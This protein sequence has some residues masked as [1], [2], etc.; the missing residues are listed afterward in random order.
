M[1]WGID[2]SLVTTNLTPDFGAP[3][4]HFQIVVQLISVLVYLWISCTTTKKSVSVLQNPGTAIDWVMNWWW[5]SLPCSTKDFSC[6]SACVRSFSICNAKD[7]VTNLTNSN[8]WIE[9]DRDERMNESE[10]WLA[11]K[12]EIARH[13][14]ELTILIWQLQKES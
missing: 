3:K 8:F 10:N 12:C 1:F 7:Y 9:K 2:L 4:G 5:R 6:S 14:T 11:R 13:N